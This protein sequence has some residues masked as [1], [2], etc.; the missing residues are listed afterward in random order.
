MKRSIAGAAC[1]LVLGAV[2]WAQSS[3]QGPALAVD[4]A[5][6]RHAISPGIYGVNEYES[7]GKLNLFATDALPASLRIAVRRFGG[8]ATSRYNWKWDNYNSGGDYFFEN[9]DYGVANPAALPSGS[10]FDEYLEQNHR[11]GAATMATIPVMGWTTKGPGHACSYSVAK[12]GPQDKT[13]PYNPD[14]GNGQRNQKWLTG[15]DPNDASAPSDTGFYQAWIQY[16]VSRYGPANRGGVAIWSMDNEPEWWMAVHHDIHPNPAT[17]D[18]MTGLNLQFAAAVK[19][20]D[21]SAHV[22]GPVPAGWSG[23]FYSALDFVSGW[24]TGPNYVY[25]GNPVDRNAHGGTAWV[26]YY[27]QQMSKYEQQHGL[28][29]LDFLDVHGYIAPD[30]IS[31]AA[32]GDAATQALRLTSTRAFWDPNYTVAATNNEAPALAP[33]M[34]D[35]VN[36]DYPGTK[37]AIT[38]YNWGALDD[39]NGALAEAD[40]LGIFG[41]E[42][43]DVAT[44]WGPPRA[45]DPGRFAFAMYR[46]YDGIG[47]AFG[48]T[49]VSAATANPDQ[50]SI[51]A[52][53]R[54]DQ[55]LTVVA[56]NK[57]AGALTSDIGLA[58]FA[59]QGTARVYR[60]SE[61]NLNAIVRQPD[62]SAS[63]SGWIATFPAYS[64]TL[65]ELPAAEGAFA[66]PKPAVGAVVNAASYLASAAPGEMVTIFGTNLGPP[67]GEVLTLGAAGLLSTEIGGG[68]ILFDGVPGPVVYISAGQC[69][70]IV[71]YIAAN[72][73][74][75]HVQV[76]YQGRRSDP[77]AI[78]VSSTAPGIFTRNEAGTS[79][80]A[81]LNSDGQ[82][83][84]SPQAP[85]ARGSVVSLFLTGE[86]QTNPPGVDGKIAREILPAPVLPV[87]ATVGGQTAEVVYAGAAPGGTAGFMQ[88]NVRIPSSALL[89]P[90][91]SV[92]VVVSVGGLRS[93]LTATLAIQ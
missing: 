72:V 86:G 42:A 4:A 74:T 29:L 65:F 23:Y 92:P 31:F 82:T 64:I 3:A 44:L 59:P 81:A 78:A 80:A 90:G 11:T 10:Y 37:I 55:T 27:L 54:S 87:T 45:T 76:Q 35:W 83:T 60:Y 41:R 51:F 18:E 46:N 8:D 33:R 13:D 20:A 43:L 73:S 67:Q 47:S 26:E 24:G 28:R 53:Q 49:G 93:Q 48:E 85:A 22:S 63:G 7:D 84:N 69:T 77:F 16:L 15:T 12:Y 50:V 62:I 9:Y 39:I 56:I 61:A 14:C 5:A 91:P 21:P 79:E 52:A 19:A 30:G 2:G 75:V 36:K 57:T 68:E 58:N 89:V 1:V 38:E 17:Y 6:L 34:R 88:V 25:N 66:V 32:A 40:I 71:P 70:A